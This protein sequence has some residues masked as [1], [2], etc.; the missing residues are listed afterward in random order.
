M[1][2]FTGSDR[3]NVHMRK[4]ALQNGFTLNEYSLRRIDEEGNPV[5]KTIPVKSEREIFE[6]IG[7]DYTPPEERNFL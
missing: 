2:Y 3:F 5:G 7:I 4:L 6:K 1:L